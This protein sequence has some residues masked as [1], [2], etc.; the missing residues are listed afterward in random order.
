VTDTSR[1]FIE[2]SRTLLT[3]SYLPRIEQAVEGLSIA[4]VWWRANADSNSI[5]NLVLHLAGNV[6]QWIGSGLGGEPDVR[7][8]HEEFDARSAMDAT[9]LLGQLRVT[10][11]AADHVLAGID[12]V[13]LLEPR[14]IQSYDVTVMRAIYTVVEHFSMH[15]GQILLLAKMFKGDLRLYDLSSGN[16]RPTWQGGMAG[17]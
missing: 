17:H 8:R 15:T 7:Q 13:T 10:V 4:N 6:R 1:L 5:G 12:P 2:Q 14:R 9:E 11:D 16:P 3:A